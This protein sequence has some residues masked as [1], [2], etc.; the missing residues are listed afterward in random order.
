MG[1]IP[2]PN[3]ISIEMLYTMELEP[4]E[5]VYHVSYTAA[6]D[7]SSLTALANV[8]KNWENTNA[9]PSRSNQCALRTIRLRDIASPS[10]QEL[11]FSVSPAISGTNTA[12]PAPNNVTIATAMR[13]GLAGRSNRGRS[14]WIGITDVMYTANNI[15]PTIQGQILAAYAALLTALSSN[16]TPL[17]VLSKY[18]GTDSNGKPIPRAAGVHTPITSVSM[19]ITMDSQRRR[20][21][22]HNRH[23]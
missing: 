5:N 23:R 1:F 20:L 16:S 19:D 17:V 14:Y 6:P 4:C 15:V 18:S 11:I 9:S 3:T 10:G 22:G 12:N 21:P 7:Q 8:F 13:T 2:C